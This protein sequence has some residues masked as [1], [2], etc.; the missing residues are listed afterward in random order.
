MTTVVNKPSD[1]VTVTGDSSLNL[2]SEDQTQAQLEQ[3]AGALQLLADQANQTQ[4]MGAEAPSEETGTTET[5]ET[6]NTDDTNQQTNGASIVDMLNAM[7]QIQAVIGDS[8]AKQAGF[9]KKMSDADI[10]DAENKLKD[11]IKKWQDYQKKLKKQK[12]WGFWSKFI[13][14]LITAVIDVVACATGQFYMAAMATGM[15]VGEVSG[16]TEAL[17]KLVSTVLQDCGMSKADAD[18][19]AS[20][21]VTLIVA[22][23]SFYSA[24]GAV[25]EAAVEEGAN[26]GEQG[27]IE[28]ANLG[29]DAGE[30]AEG[31]EEAQEA[32][33]SIKETL[34]NALKTVMKTLA[35]IF[36]PNRAMALQ[37]LTQMANDTGLS[38]A[39]AEVEV[40]KKYPNLTG[41]EKEDKIK[42]IAGDWSIAFMAAGIVTMFISMASLEE[43][44]SSLFKN[45]SKV[46][47]VIEEGGKMDFFFG[48]GGSVDATLT[49]VTNAFAKLNEISDFTKVMEMTRKI[50]SVGEATA[51]IGGAIVTLDGEIAKKDFLVDQADIQLLTVLE[52]LLNDMMSGDQQFMQ[53]QMEGSEVSVSALLRGDQAAADMLATHSPV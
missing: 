8:A 23:A 37:A 47:S 9:Q 11:A 35:K 50:L 45:G 1:S 46:D 4:T 38:T 7:G 36:P 19:F 31:A 20:I 53:S 15:Y 13:G 16:G 3:L 25:A 49:K 29:G 5:V 27:M 18:L 17:T 48:K 52:D 26:V 10:A 39:I 34:K 44:T 51:D 6:T 43:N 42:E 41:Q 33:Q 21:L 24:P 12:K 22:V 40:E 14:G 2:V 28:L 30:V 32:A